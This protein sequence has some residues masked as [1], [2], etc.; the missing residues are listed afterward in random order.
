MS[1]Y[2]IIDSGMLGNTLQERLGFED[3]MLIDNTKKSVL[4]IADFAASKCK[5]NNS[6]IIFLNADAE[7]ND[8]N[9][10]ILDIVLWLRCK[11]KFLNPI[12]IYSIYSLEKLLQ[13]NPSN[14]FIIS[15]GCVF[16]EDVDVLHN[17]EE[18]K[19]IQ[20]ITSLM[21]LKP[22]LK[23]RVDEILALYKHRMANY[24]GMALILDIVIQVYSKD[25]INIPDTKILKGNFPEFFAHRKSLYHALLSTYFDFEKLK[26]T[27]DQKKDLC[28]CNTKKILLVD[29]LADKGWQHIIT[30]MLYSNPDANQ[31]KSLKIQTKV[32]NGVNKFDYEATKKA[33]ESEIESHKPHLILLDLRLH[34]EKREIHPTQLSGYKLLELLKTSPRYKGVPVIMFTASRNAEIIKTLLNAGAEAVWIKPG[35]DEGLNLESIIIRYKQLLELTD[36]VFNPNYELFNGIQ[37]QTDESYNIANLNIEEIRQK[38]NIKLDYIR[39]RIALTQTDAVSQLPDYYNNAHA[40]YIDANALVTGS[41]SIFYHE[42]IASLLILSLLTKKSGFESQT[43]T[44][45]CPKVV[46]MNSVYDELIKMSKTFQFRTKTEYKTGKFI[47]YDLCCYR[48]PISMLLVKDLFNNNSVRTEFGRWSLKCELLNPKENIAADGY[49]LDEISNL[50][51]WNYKDNDK[52]FYKGDT[53][54]ICITGDG[55]LTHKLKSFNNSNLKVLGLKNFTNDM[56]SIIL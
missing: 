32:E 10:N 15:P 43:K 53:N 31:V 2:I 27:D 30:Q 5:D 12:V 39:Y 9:D 33:L 19:K 8:I 49:I 4:G 51:L 20:P 14:Y 52:S 50:V 28:R 1:K 3:I 44:I 13:K 37:D 22:F 40:I 7:I 11:H 47:N 41:K 23:L 42:L 46:I 24:A 29:D 6:A 36:K 35:I 16:K 54:V 25:D 26:I 18:I 45:T 17:I 55:G 38:L 48:A 21:E 56:K 34:D